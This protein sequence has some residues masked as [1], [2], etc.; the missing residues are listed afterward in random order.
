[1]YYKTETDRKHMARVCGTQ[2]GGSRLKLIQNSGSQTAN[3]WSHNTAAAAQVSTKA[4]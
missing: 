1:M 2:A 3:Q 4:Q